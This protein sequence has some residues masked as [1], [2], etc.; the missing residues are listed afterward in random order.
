[1]VSS[2]KHLAILH[3]RG[4]ISKL[5]GGGTRSKQIINNLINDV[6]PF[7]LAIFEKDHIARDYHVAH[8]TRCS[9]TNL[10]LMFTSHDFAARVN[11]YM[12]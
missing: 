9:S 4:S 11:T 12:S 10:I 8:S 5:W 7:I 3:C 2:V 6:T 1:M